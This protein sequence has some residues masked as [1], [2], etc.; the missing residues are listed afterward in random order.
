MRQSGCLGA[1]LIAASGARL[2]G[3]VPE[4]A[5]RH[6]QIERVFEPQTGRGLYAELY[7]L[8]RDLHGVMKP[9]HAALTRLRQPT[10]VSAK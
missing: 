5:R 10:A 9:T 2:V 3:S 7:Q 6:V 1:A 4:A 8:Y